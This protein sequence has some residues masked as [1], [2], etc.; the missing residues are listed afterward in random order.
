MLERR[1]MERLYDRLVE[2]TASYNVLSSGQ[3]RQT[4]VPQ[5]RSLAGK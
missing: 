3:L 1:S 2:P 4:L 5:N